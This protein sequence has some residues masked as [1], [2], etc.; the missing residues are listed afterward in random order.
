[1]KTRRKNW[2]DSNTFTPPS[3]FTPPP[4]IRLCYHSITWFVSSITPD[5]RGGVPSRIK[6]ISL[7]Q[8][9]LLP[10][11]S[12]K[13]NINFQE[14]I[15]S[16]LHCFLVSNMTVTRVLILGHSFIR[17]LREYIG[18]NADLDV[19]LH[20]LKGIELKWHMVGG[21]TVLKTVQFDLS[22]VELF[23]A[24][25]VILQLGTNDLNHLLA[26]NVGSAIED[27]TQSLH[28]LP[29]IKCVCVCQTIY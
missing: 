28:D 20:I 22:V 3:Y 5:D 23:K 26:V 17:C 12:R 19:S 29:N 2:S 13:E 4:V 21:R 15:C 18:R 9:T 24:D 1:M 16:H 7:E 27:L 11:V 8:F 10:S 25:I 14:S 6:D